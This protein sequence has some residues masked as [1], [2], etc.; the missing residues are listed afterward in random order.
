MKCPYC[1]FIDSKVIDSRP[2]DGNES[3]R[4]RRACLSCEKRFT[5]YE[6]VE[7]QT[8]VVV[9]KDNRRE[10][11][12]RSKL[13]NSL[14]KSC[15]KRPI[16]VS[17]LEDAVDEIEREINHLNQKEIT[18]AYI[19]DLV[20]DKLKEIDKVAYVRFA[21]VYREFEDVQSFADEIENLK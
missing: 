15:E 19:G 11:F 6:R 5:T 17:V 14:I 10:S 13:L 21:S 20:M 3:I 18:S 1:G 7:D 2:T 8:I 12:Q 9:K 16:E 4:R